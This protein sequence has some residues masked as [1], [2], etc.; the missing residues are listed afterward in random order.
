MIVVQNVTVAQSVQMTA[1]FRVVNV[2]F[3]KELAHFE[4]GNSRQVTVTSGLVLGSF[5]L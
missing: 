3:K 1:V 5:T 2:V 4:K